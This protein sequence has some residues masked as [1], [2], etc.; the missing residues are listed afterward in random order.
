MNAFI[1]SVK[2][3][4]WKLPIPG[5]MKEKMRQV[6]A[7]RKFKLEK[8]DETL[9]CVDDPEMIKK[10]VQYVLS[11]PTKKVEDK[12]E[13]EEHKK[14]RKEPYLIAYYLTQYSPD[15]HNDIWWGKGTTEWNNVAKAVPQFEN[16]RQPLLPGEFGFYDLRIK[17]VMQR[18]IEVAKNYGL[19]AFSFYYY[20]FAG[21]RILEKPLTMF[22]EDKSLDM[23]FM[24]CWANENWTK[25]F[26]GTDADILIGMDN[27]VENYKMF[28]HEVMP[29][30][31]DNRYFKIKGKPVLQVYRPSLIPDVENVILYWKSEV[32][33][34]CGMDLY[35]IACQ[36]KDISIN[37]EKKGF[38]AENEWMCES[39]RL[40]ARDITK[41]VNLIRKDFSGEIYD[42][43]DLVISK[44][45]EIK[46]NKRR[47]VYPA[48]MPSWDNSARR[49]NKGTVWLGSTPAL[50]KEWLSVKLDEVMNRKDLD[51]PLLFI[52][53][54]N[55]WGEGAYLEPD[56]DY[57]FAYLQATWEA[58]E[59]I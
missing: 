48:V 5:S 34:E 31:K 3:I 32:K 58:K 30:F 18:Q 40:Q 17:E 59:D 13:Y 28:I 14:C 47:K 45:Y 22:L 12:C 16:H 20:W 50:Y 10:Y 36:T 38:D 29:Y 6:Y 44:K 56:R 46:D 11:L 19:N 55:E 41:Q 39:V 35:L 26:S 7:D 33:K 4:F 51:A 54:W 49:N 9:C 52:N 8:D 24:L 1:K 37:W 25:R 53:A 21:E 57:G 15:A 43:R 42:Y 23:P 2:K 27:T